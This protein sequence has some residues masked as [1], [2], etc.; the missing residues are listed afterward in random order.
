MYQ[1]VI[2]LTISVFLSPSGLYDTQLA[3]SS[4]H[5]SSNFHDMLENQP[6]RLS[7]QGPWT[8]R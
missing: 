7:L 1:T 3:S 6:P 5:V 4:V 8:E 2:N